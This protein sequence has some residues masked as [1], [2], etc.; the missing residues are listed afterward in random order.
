MK[1]LQMEESSTYVET[2]FCGCSIKR[3]SDQSFD[4]PPCSHY[5]R[6]TGKCIWDVADMLAI[7]R[8]RGLA[9][10]LHLLREDL[11]SVKDL[12][13]TPTFRGSYRLLSQR[14]KK[15]NNQ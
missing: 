9:K 5:G 12:V 11:D 8:N 13:E 2:F 1:T 4:G 10:S 7:Y 15:R 3:T 6:E 14:L